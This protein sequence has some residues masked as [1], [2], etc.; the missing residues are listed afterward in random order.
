MSRDLYT[1]IEIDAPVDA[2]WRRSPTPAP[3]PNGTPSSGASRA[4][5]TRAPPSRSTSGRRARAG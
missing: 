5:Y 2:V 1:E 4:T 3:T